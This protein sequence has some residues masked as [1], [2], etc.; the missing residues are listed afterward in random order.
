MKR[1]LNWFKKKRKPSLK[2][3][4]ETKLDGKVLYFAYYKG[5]CQKCFYT[6]KEVD[7]WVNEVVLMS[8]MGFP[9]KE[10]VKYIEI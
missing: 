7:E 10:I 3:V 4:K 1:L 6:Q 2:I 5:V 9:I 8:A